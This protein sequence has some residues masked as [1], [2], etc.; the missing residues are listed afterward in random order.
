VEAAI[1]GL[2]QA[3]IHLATPGITTYR[4]PQEG[5]SVNEEIKPR[6]LVVDDEE[7]I[8]TWLTALLVSLGCEIAGEAKDG[9]EGVEMFKKERPD[10]V[11][12]DIQMPEVSGSLALEYIL[13]EDPDARVIVLSSVTDG[14]VIH[15]LVTAGAH[16]YLAK[17]NPPD[18]VRSALVEQIEKVKELRR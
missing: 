17:D 7:A 2:S 3:R 15:D 8:R 5:R 9:R 14:S 13:T 1:Y 18:Q 6:V 10:L 12:L 16:Y 11:L 4:C